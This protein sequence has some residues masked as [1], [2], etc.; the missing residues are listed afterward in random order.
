MRFNGT[1][2]SE[3]LPS[4][5]LVGRVYIGFTLVSVNGKPATAK[6]LKARR[7]VLEKN[8]NGVAPRTVLFRAP[9]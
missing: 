2:V 5:P 4:S 7:G 6:S 8:D 1:T 3:V 9:G